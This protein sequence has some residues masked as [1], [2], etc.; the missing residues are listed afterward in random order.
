MG[1]SDTGFRRKSL[2]SVGTGLPQIRVKLPNL[3][4]QQPKIQQHTCDL[5]TCAPHMSGSEYNRSRIRHCLVALVL[6]VC[7]GQEITYGTAKPTSSISGAIRQN[8]SGI[9][10]CAV[11]V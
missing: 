11:G 3:D 10:V 7:L 1:L 4:I 2:A 6:S 8:V 5:C 9:Q